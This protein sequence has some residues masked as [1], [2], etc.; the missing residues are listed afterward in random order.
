MV[1]KTLDE[2]KDVGI[3]V[4]TSGNHVFKKN[5]DNKIFKKYNLIRPANYPE[6]VGVPG[7]GFLK[8][9]VN[10][11]NIY[12]LNL[13][14]RVFIQEDFDCPFR[15]FDE[16][17]KKINFINQNKFSNSNLK[18][19]PKIT[20]KI[21]LFHQ[22][23]IVLMFHQALSNFILWLLFRLSLSYFFSWFLDLFYQILILEHLKTC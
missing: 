9:R 18:S 6:N 13:M 14:G 7:S 12:I 1:E 10:N 2:M 3:E 11:K 5:T 21:F 19:A 22:K 8:I 16:L 17:Q 4:F 20:R 23:F 15:K